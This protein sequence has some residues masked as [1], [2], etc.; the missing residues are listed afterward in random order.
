[1]AA[2]SQRESLS[3]EAGQSGAEVLLPSVE[4]AAVSGAG[5]MESAQC[6]ICMEELA[7]G[8]VTPL[9]GCSHAFHSSCIREWFNMAPTPT[10]PSCRR[11]MTKQR[12]YMTAQ[13]AIDSHQKRR[14]EEAAETAA[15]ATLSVRRLRRQQRLADLLGVRVRRVA[16]P[17]SDGQRQRQVSPGVYFSPVVLTTRDDAPLFQYVSSTQ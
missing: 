15:A 2:A 16:P 1:M 14:I 5:K 10:C 12:A 6:P 3:T 13:A 11:D 4:A 8:G 9:P 17:P 7:D